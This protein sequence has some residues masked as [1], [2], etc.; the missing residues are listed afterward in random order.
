[1]SE[2]VKCK[3]IVVEGYTTICADTGEV[4]EER[5]ILS[6]PG[7]KRE[8]DAP[9]ANTLVKVNPSVH[10]YAIGTSVDYRSRSYR[11]FKALHEIVDRAGFEQFVRARAGVLLRGALARDRETPGKTLA[12]AAVYRAARDAGYLSSEICERIEAGDKCFDIA[13]LAT[14][15]FKT[16]LGANGVDVV[17]YLLYAVNTLPGIPLDKR[18]DVVRLAREY[19]EKAAPYVVTPR[20]RLAVAVYMACQDLGIEVDVKALQQVFKTKTIIERYADRIRSA[21]KR[22]RA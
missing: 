19:Y 3:N 16:P 2:P 21:L 1:M 22:G 8:E 20:T 10:D 11:A 7:W 9:D 17:G 15:L 4:I 12:M 13:T 6:V 5:P 18:G 14:R